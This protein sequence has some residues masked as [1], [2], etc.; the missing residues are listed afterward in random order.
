MID[1]TLM[2]FSRLRNG[3]IGRTMKEHGD[4]RAKRTQNDSGISSN[5]RRRNE[6]KVARRA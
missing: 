6:G 1:L 5:G 4:D 2:S 3:S